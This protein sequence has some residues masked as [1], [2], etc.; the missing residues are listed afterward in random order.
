M[1]EQKTVDTVEK[2]LEAMGSS[3][4]RYILKELQEGP[5]ALVPCLASLM[6]DKVLRRAIEKTSETRRQRSWAKSYPRRS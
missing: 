3:D 4:M 6:R 5:P 2:I 1:N